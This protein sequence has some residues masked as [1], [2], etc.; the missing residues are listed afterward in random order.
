M[1]KPHSWFISRLYHWALGLQGFLAILL[2][3]YPVAW[4]YSI[5]CGRF[6]I[7]IPK[8]NQC[9]L[10]QVTHLFPVFFR[11]LDMVSR[12]IT[13]QE[14]ADQPVI[15]KFFVPFFL[16]RWMTFSFLIRGI[17]QLLWPFTADMKQP[18]NDIGHFSWNLWNTVDLP[19]SD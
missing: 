17:P 4:G 6:C 16:K 5:T 2:H 7:F 14:L 3:T 1:A 18:C 11:S 9:W 10:F 15:P 19:A 13:S 8:I 12:G